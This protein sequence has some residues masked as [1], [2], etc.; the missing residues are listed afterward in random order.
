G[1]TGAAT[2]TWHLVVALQMAE[3]PGLEVWGMLAVGTVALAVAAGFVWRGDWVPASAPKWA[4]GALLIGLAG[5][6]ILDSEFW[7]ETWRSTASNLSVGG[8]YGSLIV[9]VGVASILALLRRRTGL[10]FLVF[11]VLTAVPLGL[12]FSFLRGIPYRTGAGDSFSRM[13]LHW[14]PLAVVGAVATVGPMSSWRP[15]RKPASQH[16]SAVISVTGPVNT[17]SE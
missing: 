13:L 10:G 14:L 12:T 17:D 8:P 11:P 6:A 4:A 5:L 3:G 9:V 2:V 1:V 16:G 15:T 7:T